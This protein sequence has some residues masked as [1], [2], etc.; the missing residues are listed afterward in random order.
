MSEEQ[1]RIQTFVYLELLYIRHVGLT[2]NPQYFPH[3]S[4]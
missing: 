3:A 2:F 1:K 4:H